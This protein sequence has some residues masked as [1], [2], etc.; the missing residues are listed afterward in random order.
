MIARARQPEGRRSLSAQG[1]AG[2]ASHAVRP[3][4]RPA[5]PSRPWVVQGKQGSPAEAGTRRVARRPLRRLAGV[6]LALG[7]GCVECLALARAR[8]RS[9]RARAG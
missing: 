9:R 3:P 5:A 4:Q 1:A 6:V 2:D 8:H 7:W